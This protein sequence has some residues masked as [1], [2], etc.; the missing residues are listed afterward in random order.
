M[1]RVEEMISVQVL[2]A[3]RAAAMPA[4]KIIFGCTFRGIADMES[5]ASGFLLNIHA[6]VGRI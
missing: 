3:D 4:W 5:V 2:Y 1:A 6:E